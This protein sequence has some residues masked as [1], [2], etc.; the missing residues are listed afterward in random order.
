ML[1]YY[2][3]DTHFNV[4]GNIADPDLAVLIRATWSWF[5]IEYDISDPTQLDL[6]H[7]FFALCTNVKVYYTYV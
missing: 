6:A 2:L 1:T 7:N 4:F 5:A 3:I